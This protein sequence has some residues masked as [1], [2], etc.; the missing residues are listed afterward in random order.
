VDRAEAAAHRYPSRP[1]DRHFDGS[2]RF[3]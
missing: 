1:A 2:F 3:V